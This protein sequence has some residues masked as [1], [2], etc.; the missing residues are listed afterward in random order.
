MNDDKDTKQ[1]TSASSKPLKI[2]TA[3]KTFLL[4]F[5]TATAGVG[6]IG[7]SLYSAASINSQTGNSYTKP[8]FRVVKPLSINKKRSISSNYQS[9][10][11]SNNYLSIPTPFISLS[12]PLQTSS[13]S[14]KPTHNNTSTVAPPTHTTTP[15]N[16][17]SP[18]ASQAVATV[19]PVVHTTTAMPIKQPNPQPVHTQ[20]SP[21]SVRGNPHPQPVKINPPQAVRISADIQNQ[22]KD[23]QKPAQ[24]QPSPGVEITKKQLQIQ[25]QILESNT[26]IQTKSNSLDNKEVNI[27]IQTK[28]S[29]QIS[30]NVHSDPI[31]SIVGKTK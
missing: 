25:T 23:H 24:S 20:P 2:V 16:I 8:A 14:L 4:G 11:F 12:Q 10:I 3:H 29:A 9:K 17:L 31:K 19:A 13:I 5:F 15:N 27:K 26:S 22:T 30:I 7:I 1:E 18:M 21:Q 6:L 28:M